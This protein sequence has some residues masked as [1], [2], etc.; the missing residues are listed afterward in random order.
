MGV[1]G[2]VLLYRAADLFDGRLTFAFCNGRKT[3]GGYLWW[4]NSFLRRKDPRH[5]GC[6]PTVPSK[7][8]IG[9]CLGTVSGR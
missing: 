1:G 9:R 5:T 3:C 2:F 7:S 4:E 6:F 8:T